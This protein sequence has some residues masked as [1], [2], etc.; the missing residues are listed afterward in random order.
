[1]PVFDYT[2][3][4]SRGR[5]IDGSVEAPDKQSVIRDLRNIRYTVTN[6]KERS[7]PLRFAKELGARFQRADLYSVA[8]FTR[9]FAVLFNAGISTVRSLDGLG[10]QTLN[11][12]L[13]KAVHDVH[14]DVRMGYTLAK[15]M[16]KHPNVFDQ[17]YIAMVRAGEMS[18][19][20]FLL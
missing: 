17:L 1:M 4:D 8:I 9:Q 16:S 20:M 6:I 15:A 3:V 18:G 13:S 12:P 2:A 19:S 10:R 11:G 14:D 7:D 5:S